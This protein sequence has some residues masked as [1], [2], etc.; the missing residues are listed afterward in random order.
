[1]LCLGHVLLRHM[2]CVSR[3]QRLVMV[4]NCSYQVMSWFCACKQESDSAEQLMA[5]FGKAATLIQH[6]EYVRCRAEQAG[7]ARDDADVAFQEDAVGVTDVD[8]DSLAAAKQV[9]SELHRAMHAALSTSNGFLIIP[10]IPG[11]PV[12]QRYLLTY[13]L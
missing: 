2:G 10:T 3:R 12:L 1:M 13:A 8:A 11:P 9:Q 4:Y 6:S 7:Q 5:A